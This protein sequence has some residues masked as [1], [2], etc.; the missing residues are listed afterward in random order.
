MSNNAFTGQLE[1]EVKVRLLDRSSFA[2]KLPLQGFRLLTPNTLERNIL[3]DTPEGSLRDR[4]EI[5]RIRKYGE[6]WKLTHKSDA[7]TPGTSAHKVR[8]ETELGISDGQAL[9]GILERLGYRQVFVYEKR[10][11]E[12]TDGAGHLVLDATPIGDFVELEGDHAWIDA[13]AKKL[14]ILPSEY[15][16]ASYA[17][18]FSDWKNATKH[19][20]NNMTFDDI[21]VHSATND[22]S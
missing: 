3:F 13:T 19:P 16:T 11:E 1:T 20:A 12:W 2:A 14:G 6:I 21:G 17:R 15:S 18:L 9:M 22:P 5:L 4:R 10:R 8:I 7:G